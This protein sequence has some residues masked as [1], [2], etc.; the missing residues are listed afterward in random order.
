MHSL[1]DGVC[2]EEKRGAL[3]ANHDGGVIADPDLA[4]RWLR[5]AATDGLYRGDFAVG[6]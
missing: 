6:S 3:R 2:R 5:Q 1:D 4:L